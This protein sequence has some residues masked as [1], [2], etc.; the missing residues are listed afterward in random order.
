MLLT[1]QNM[2]SLTQKLKL[3]S[4]DNP[5]Y[6]TTVLEKYVLC[7]MLFPNSPIKIKKKAQQTKI[8]YIDLKP[9]LSYYF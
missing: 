4:T 3:F 7:Y 5:L 2:T 1:Q 8:G 6:S 9:G